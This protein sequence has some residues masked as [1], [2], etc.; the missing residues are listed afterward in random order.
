MTLKEDVTSLLCLVLKC[1]LFC[2]FAVQCPPECH[3]CDEIGC[4][5]CRQG[6]LLQNGRCIH[7]CSVGFFQASDLRCQ[8]RPVALL[9][10][11]EI[12]LS[13]YFDLSNLAAYC[14]I[15]LHLTWIAHLIK[16]KS[17]IRVCGILVGWSDPQLFEDVCYYKYILSILL[18]G[19]IL[20][21]KTKNIGEKFCL[22]KAKLQS[23]INFWCSFV[24]MEVVTNVFGDRKFNNTLKFLR[25]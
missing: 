2:H 15:F 21:W 22:L 8:G 12:F 23:F 19:S 17:N 4:T 5:S 25:F 13:C 16:K 3:S 6:H 20:L 10:R 14:R 18:W 7:G 24:L 9:W 11:C 1:L